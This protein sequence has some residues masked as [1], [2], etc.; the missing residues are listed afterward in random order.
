MSTEPKSLEALAEEMRDMLRVEKKPFVQVGIEWM[1]R[2]VGC[3]NE[4]LAARPASDLERRLRERA[5]EFA[6]DSMA[7]CDDAELLLEAADALALERADTRPRCDKATLWRGAEAIKDAAREFKLRK[8]AELERD[9]LG[10][11]CASY[12]EK[13]KLQRE[14]LD[15]LERELVEKTKA[16]TGYINQLQAA[17]A[18][19]AAVAPL[20]ERCLDAI[21]VHA[22]TVL[23]EDITQALAAPTQEKP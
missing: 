14:K 15:E 18:R 5:H 6:D 10:N 1:W 9:M 3:L 19:L 16:T 8:A 17:E 2:W 7:M 21:N 4:H 13:F 23:Y 20:L 11:M 22:E 12:E